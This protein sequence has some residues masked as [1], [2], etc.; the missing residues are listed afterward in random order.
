MTNQ[1]TITPSAEITTTTFGPVVLSPDK[2]PAAVY[3]ASLSVGSRRTM[4][5]AIDDIALLLSGGH[6]DAVTMPWG[7][8]R[9][10]HTEAVRAALP[11]ATNEKGEKRYSASTCNKMLSALRGTLKRAWRLGYMSAEQYQLAIDIARVKGTKVDQA[12]GRSLTS[13]EITSLMRAC[14]EDESAKGVRD[15][16][17]I[18][19]A[20]AAG[21]RR[22]EISNLTMADFDSSNCMF[23]ITSKGNKERSIYIGPSAC[24]VLTGWLSV[25]GL[26]DG[27]MFLRIYK[28]GKVGADGISDQAVY[29]MM[30]DR[31]K[32]AG[33]KAFSPHD[34]RRTFAGDMFDA[35]VDVSTVQKIMGHASANTTAS[36][37]R[38]GER[39]KKSAAA[40]IDVPIVR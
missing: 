40:M 7:M 39:A 20:Y 1:I 34:M 5:K 15:A 18:A 33:V 13:A 38:R 28:G 31:A 6:C 3:I 24:E 22:S 8:V 12:A 25:R 10:E 16:A 29:D 19:I 32:E 14:A 26:D 30:L 37:D 23:I 2:Q 27:P 11:E 21:L 17:M 4:S 35:K 36:Y 9:I